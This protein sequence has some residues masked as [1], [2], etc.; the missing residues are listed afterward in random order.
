VVHPI[1]HHAA[2]VRRIVE[3]PGLAHVHFDLSWNETA[4]YLV[5]TSSSVAL[6]ADII[7]RHPDRFLFGTDEV[8]PPD[9]KTYLRIRQQYAPLWQRLDR[10]ASEKLRRGNYERLFDEARRRV[11]AWERSQGLGSTVSQRP[12]G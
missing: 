5:A 1:E 8:S 9:Q 10:A 3:D 11:R 12:P 7:G 4:K 6:A 2:M